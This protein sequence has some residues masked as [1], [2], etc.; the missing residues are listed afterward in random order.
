MPGRLREQPVLPVPQRPQAQPRTGP[1]A[2]VKPCGQ[3]FCGTGRVGACGG[4]HAALATWPGKFDRPWRPGV[5]RCM[6]HEVVPP[7]WSMEPGAPRRSRAPVRRGPQATSRAAH[8]RDR[9]QTMAQL[10]RGRVDLNQPGSPE[11]VARL[12]CINTRRRFVSTVVMHR[13][14]L[15]ASHRRAIRAFARPCV[16]NI[17]GKAHE[18]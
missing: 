13:W 2:V 7:L 1:V 11:C 10:R 14:R 12:I 3:A 4:I 16:E 17:R 6:G 9:R 15:S 18:N 8:R 5:R